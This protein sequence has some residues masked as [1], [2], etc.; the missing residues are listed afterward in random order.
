MFP[1]PLRLHSLAYPILGVC[2]VRCHARLSPSTCP[3]QQ[4]RPSKVPAQLFFDSSV[5][6][7]PAR[8]LSFL[9]S[10]SRH[11]I[12]SLST[13]TT[14]I[15]P[16]IALVKVSFLDSSQLYVTI[17]RFYSSIHLLITVI[18]SDMLRSVVYG[19]IW[20]LIDVLIQF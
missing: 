1:K 8:I 17:M 6:P 7:V 3:A 16:K 15:S 2:T 12:P 10:R 14:K 18:A 11:Y 9:L 5:S 4:Q 13:C 20:M 19:T